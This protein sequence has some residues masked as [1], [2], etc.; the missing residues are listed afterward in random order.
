MAWTPEQKKAIEL[1]G[2]NIIVSA[3]AGSGK[4]AVLTTRVLEKL[5]NGTHINELLILTFTNAA[6]AEMK[7]RIKTNIEKNNLLNELDLLDTSY[8]TTFDS[9]ALSIVKKYHYLLN[10]SNKINITDSSLIALQKRKILDDIF[11][12]NYQNPSINFQNLINTL[13]IKDDNNLKEEILRI[14]NKLSIKTDLNT[15]L[16]NYLVEY[17]SEANINKLINDYQNILNQSVNEL[18]LELENYQ[19]DF[20]TDYYTKLQETFSPL[21]SNDLDTL[22]ATIKALKLPSLKRGSDEISKFAKEKINKKLKELKSITIYGYK[23]NIINDYK[24][25][26]SLIEPL[27]SILKDFFNNLTTYKRNNEIYDFTDIAKL[28]L[29]ILKNNKSIRLELKNYFK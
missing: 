15:Y 1:T 21:K 3:G 2:T 20:E 22:I 17:Y 5:K 6:A 23:E 27:L 11:E 25:T 9:F 8:I 16:N 26:K 12:K 29:E 24:D 7:Q 4:T 10:I 18:F 14:A 13:C 19:M 28:S